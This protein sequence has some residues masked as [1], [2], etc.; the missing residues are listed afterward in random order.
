MRTLDR[1]MQRVVAQAHLDHVL[2]R[3]LHCLGD[4]DRH[5]AC[6]AIAKADAACTIAHHRECREA[7][8]TTTFNDLRNAVDCYELL[9]QFIAGCRVFDSGH[10]SLYPDLRTS[11]HSRGPRRLQPSGGREA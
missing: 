2:A 10:M 7:E 3:L 1:V 9:E 4:G 11:D 5:F 8:L 6:L